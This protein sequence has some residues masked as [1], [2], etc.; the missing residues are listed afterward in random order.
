MWREHLDWLASAGYRAIALDLPGFGEAIV[1]PG[2]QAPWEDVLQTLHDLK[3]PQ[4]VLVGDSFGAAV[5]LRVAAVAPAA[6]SAMLLVSPPP[7]ARDPSPALSAAWEAETEA[8]ARGDIEAAVTAVVDA[9]L[10]P[11][12]PAALRERVAA[13]QRRAL[14]L[15][16]AAKEPDEAPDPLEGRSEAL[17][18]LRIPVVAVA[19]E[20]DMPDFKAGAREVADLVS[21]GRCELIA[22]AGHLAP[23]EA[24]EE[25]Q[26]ILLGLLDDLR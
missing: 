4:A 20:A 8:L 18:A 16:A 15:Q 11:D 13:M 24:P 10:Q 21:H 23:L 12:A 3:V 25:F 7:L 5:C 14:E 9:W 26:R 2:R 22:G 6:V 17:R 19:G 1:Q